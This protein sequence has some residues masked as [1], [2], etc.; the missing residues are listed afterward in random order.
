MD[1]AYVAAS[2]DMIKR[3]MSGQTYRQVA[4]AMFE[5]LSQAAGHV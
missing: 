1:T 2:I 4:T 3:V 5:C